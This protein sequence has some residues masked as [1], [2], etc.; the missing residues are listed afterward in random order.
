M[1]QEKKVFFSK[2]TDPFVNLA[3]EKEFLERTEIKG[4]ILFLYSS[5]TTR[6]AD[7]DKARF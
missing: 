2:S 4:Q 5:L 6:Q 7:A 1:T 3:I